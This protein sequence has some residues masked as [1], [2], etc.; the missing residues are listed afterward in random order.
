MQS[1]PTDLDARTH[2]RCWQSLLS[3]SYLGFLNKTDPA[4]VTTKQVLMGRGNPYYVQG[5]NFS[6]IG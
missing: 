4:Y 1:I 3:L 5:K 6:G 2:E